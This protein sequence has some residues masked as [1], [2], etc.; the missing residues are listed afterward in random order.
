MDAKNI[1][2]WG[3]GS[4]DIDLGVR[5]L[6]EL[7]NSS[8]GKE[9]VLPVFDK[10]I[11][12]RNRIPRIITGKVDFVFFE[13]FRIGTTQQGYGALHD[14]LDLLIALNSDLE[15]SKAWRETAGWNDSRAVFNDDRMRFQEHFSKLWSG[16]EQQ[17]KIVMPEV[18]KKS[19]L[20]ISVEDD[21]MWTSITRNQER[22]EEEHKE[23][24]GGIDLTSDKMNLQM[25]NS[26]SG[27]QFNFDPV[28]LRK[29]QNASGFT[30]VIIDIR[31][32]TTSVQMFL[33]VKSEHVEAE[34][35]SMR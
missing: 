2:T 9:V 16:I 17:A 21:H 11:L 23:N 29:L 30:P 28:M 19:D 1:M 26:A 12:D 22:E 15:R 10:K 14:Q 3:L 5:I 24:A 33:G 18:L 31:P 35:L 7:K 6:K 27:I 4:H 25:R 32:M 8:E 34:K 13:G 20:V